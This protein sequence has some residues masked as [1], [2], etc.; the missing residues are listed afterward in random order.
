VLPPNL[1]ALFVAPLNKLEVDYMISG[2]VAA[3][4]YG[5]PRLTTDVD[6]IIALPED[7]IPDFHAI[8]DPEEFYVPPVEVLHV[9]ARR[10]T[11]GHFNVIHMS[12]AFRADMY[13]AGADPLIAWGLE[14]RRPTGIADQTFWI[15]PPEYVI[16]SKLQYYRD[17]GSPKHLDDIRTMLRIS[18]NAIDQVVLEE[19]VALLNLRPQWTALGV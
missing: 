2:G 13:I 15:A 6:L 19:H 1:F 16:L 11:Y 5:E 9:E 10:R 7:I 17:G 8:F 14:R 18:G 3:I 12:S 4:I